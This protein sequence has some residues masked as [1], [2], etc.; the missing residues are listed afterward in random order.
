MTTKNVTRLR[1][2]IIQCVNNND[3]DGYVVTHGTDTLEETAFY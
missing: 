3:Y 2:T 1:E